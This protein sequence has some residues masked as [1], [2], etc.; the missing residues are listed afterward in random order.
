MKI[1]KNSSEKTCSSEISKSVLSPVSLRMERS[2]CLPQNGTETDFFG[3]NRGSQVR[4]NSKVFKFRRKSV[5]NDVF[6]CCVVFAVVTSFLPRHVVASE[7]RESDTK[8]QNSFHNSKLTNRTVDPV[9]L[10]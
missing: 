4:K 6:L 2:Y 10:L 9:S 3:S 7:D 8:L 5:L 1:L